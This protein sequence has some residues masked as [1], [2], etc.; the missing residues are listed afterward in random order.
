V[1]E[2]EPR[3][4]MT[5]EDF[6]KYRS[7][8]IRIEKENGD[9]FKRLQDGK[10]QKEDFGSRD[11]GVNDPSQPFFTRSG[12]QDKLLQAGAFIKM[13]NGDVFEVKEPLQS[14]KSKRGEEGWDGSDRS[15]YVQDLGAG[16]AQEYRI[17]DLSEIDAVIPRDWQKRLEGRVARSEVNYQS[18]VKD[19]LKL[20]KFDPEGI[21]K[22]SRLIPRMETYS[23][24][25][26]RERQQ[27]TGDARDKI[28]E[29]QG[30]LSDLIEKLKRKQGGGR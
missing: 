7:R 20:G 15:L 30:K 18:E 3:F 25:L 17:D 4:Q 12:Y 8:D 1:A 5:R 23:R 13:K 21:T 26:T 10:P 14:R 16:N 9:L 11:A 19:A 6:V 28:I 29:E 2:T 24:Q 27:A 22:R